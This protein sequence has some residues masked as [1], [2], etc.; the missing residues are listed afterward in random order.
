MPGFEFV[1]RSCGAGPTVKNVLGGLTAMKK[2][3]MVILA[4]GSVSIAGSAS[5]GLLGPLLADFPGNAGG[6]SNRVPCIVDPDV[7]LAV[8]D[9]NARKIGTQADISGGSGAQTI[10]CLVHSVNFIVVEDKTATEPTKVR[11]N[12]GHHHYLVA[13]T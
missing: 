7:V 11:F 10:A 6:K 5:V 1:Y 9:A 2:G 3:D 13:A 12:M 8:T 4:A